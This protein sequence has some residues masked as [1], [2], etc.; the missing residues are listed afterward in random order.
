MQ[1][2][3]YF[4]AKPKHTDYPIC[5]IRTRDVNLPGLGTPA[6]T[7]DDGVGPSR[8]VASALVGLRKADRDPISQAAAKGLWINES[9][10]PVVDLL[11]CHSQTGPGLS[12]R[13]PCHPTH[14]V[15]AKSTD[16]LPTLAFCM[17]TPD[18][19]SI[20]AVPSVMYFQHSQLRPCEAE[21]LLPFDM[22]DNRQG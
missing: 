10:S 20:K 2:S 15:D 13:I 22:V 6:P 14:L 19:K 11:R 12:F 4:H 7:G 9:F 18:S 8:Q 16:S 17:S 1:P 5:R 21:V 3:Y